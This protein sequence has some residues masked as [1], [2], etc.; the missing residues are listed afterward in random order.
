MTGDSS[1]MILDTSQGLKKPNQRIKVDDKTM[2][3]A[4]QE[5]EKPVVI[6]PT[7]TT[8]QGY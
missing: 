7:E 2:L 4:N 8:H 3:A 1:A 6:R 5:E